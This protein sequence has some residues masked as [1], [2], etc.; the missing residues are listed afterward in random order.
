V[1]KYC[2]NI[3]LRILI[4][5]L[6]FAS[7]LL[8]ILPTC[9]FAQTSTST[10]KDSSRAK[11]SS[12]AKARKF[13]VGDINIEVADIFEESELAWFYRAV[14]SAKISTRIEIIRRELL[15]AEG[16][17]YDPFLVA[18]SERNLRSLPF[19]RQVSITPVP[20]GEK[21]NFLVRVQDTWTLF[22]F[23]NLSTGGGSSSSAIGLTEGNFLGYG[24]RLEL[25]VA[26]D[27]GRDKIEGVYDDRRLFGSYNR[28]TL[29]HFE[30][31]DGYRSVTSLGRP[32]RSLVD[33]YAW[34]INTNFFDLVGRLFKDGD[35]SFI[36]R[37]RK[38]SVSAGY[39]V[40]KGDPEKVLRRY[41]FGY[42]YTEDNYSQADAED[43]DDINLD[44]RSVNQD[45][46]LLAEDR[47]FSGP[48]FAFQ[49]IVPDYLSINFVDRFERVED[50][51]LGN[52]LNFR[53][54]IAPEALGSSDDTLLLKASTTDGW[55]LTPTAFFRAEIS[56]A[57]RVDS[58]EVSNVLVGARLKF[59]DIVGALQLGGFYIGKHTIASSLSIDTGEKLDRDFQL[60]LGA[61]NGLRGY[62]DRTFSGDHR[63]VLNLEDRFYL[64]EDVF[65]LLSI[66]GALFFDA[67]GTSDDGFSDLIKDHLYADVGFGLRFGV[68]RS[69]GGAVIRADVA[70]P[71][72]DGPDGSGTF[73]PRF[74]VTAGQAFSAK[75]PSETLRSQAA[76]VS[77]G[78][79]P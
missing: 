66:G 45:P 75:L 44:P 62:K 59:Y 11:T 10:S 67:G 69:S 13:K 25:L 35:E 38:S 33:P 3:F 1:S 30:R 36:Y 48:L 74:I 34:S 39:T 2:E 57:S 15:F 73:E 17:N 55:R 19:L 24:K 40:P 6:L 31:S 29:G 22:P 42:D 79:L 26:D 16:D 9:A 72:R 37:Q 61:G 52:E 20:D 63:I 32:F 46:S 64:V 77:A 5:Q 12:S 68:S 4:G 28:L 14:N 65:R 27:E 8:I 78:F 50:F 7:L 41:T 54:Q 58:H 47:R 76:S 60:L 23:I 18:E 21:I 56:G 49:R 71:L 53:A 51:N 43:F 70:F